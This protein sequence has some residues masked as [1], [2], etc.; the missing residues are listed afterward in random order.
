MN[1][2]ESSIQAT[3]SVQPVKGGFIVSYPGDS[4]SGYPFAT[5]VTTSISKAL[6]IVRTQVEKFS[7]LEKEEK[8]EASAE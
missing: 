7:L 8:A 1:S 6:K 5:E 2:L 4:D 3:I